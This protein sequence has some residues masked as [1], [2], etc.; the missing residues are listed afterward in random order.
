MG[1]AAGEP[2]DGLHLLRLPRAVRELLLLGHVVVDRVVAQAPFARRHRH[3]VDLDVHE[4]A[5]LPPAD[6]RGP[7]HPAGEGRAVELLG[8]VGQRQVLRHQEPVDELPLGF[9]LAVLEDP[10]E[11]GV[12]ELDAS[13]EIHRDDRHRTVGDQGIELAVR[14]WVVCSLRR[15]A[16][17]FSR[18]ARSV[19]SPM[20]SRIANACRRSTAAVSSTAPTT[21][22]RRDAA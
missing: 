1:H 21:S 2:A 3:P 5:V 11:G 8:L 4:R 20:F 15:S 14:S 22:P 17:S 18:A 6:R 9:V 16:A 13:L 12:D 7:H 19:T 10:L